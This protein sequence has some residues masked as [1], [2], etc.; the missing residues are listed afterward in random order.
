MILSTNGT[1]FQLNK[2]IISRLVN[3]DVKT[4]LVT[5]NHNI[6]FPKYTL[7]VPSYEDKYNKFAIRHIVDIIIASIRLIQQQ[8]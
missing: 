7:I 1:I 8:Q 2:R 3:A 5:C 4:W 6:E